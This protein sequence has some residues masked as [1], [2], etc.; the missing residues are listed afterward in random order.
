M[1]KQTH[2]QTNKQ[3]NKSVYRVAAQLKMLPAWFGARVTKIVNQTFSSL[4]Y[5]YWLHRSDITNVARFGSGA[6][7]VNTNTHT[8]KTSNLLVCLAPSP[9][10]HH[11]PHHS[12][13]PPF[14][15][16]A[17]LIKGL[18]AYH[19]VHFQPKLL[20]PINLNCEDLY[21]CG[22]EPGLNSIICASTQHPSVYNA[23]YVIVTH[24]QYINSG[25]GGSSLICVA[26]MPHR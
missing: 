23:V 14:F 16:I 18:Q 5:L 11:A 10:A 1:Y 17:I 19:A 6:F 12:H 20:P 26:A 22:V 2:K 3:T 7:N 15:V 8:A 9:P 13:P 4:N 25:E 21:L 24:Y